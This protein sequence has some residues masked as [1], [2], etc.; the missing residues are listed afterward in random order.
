[1]A[2]PPA[3]ILT[4]K[5]PKYDKVGIQAWRMLNYIQSKM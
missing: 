3:T 2:L 5:I 4:Q 1:M